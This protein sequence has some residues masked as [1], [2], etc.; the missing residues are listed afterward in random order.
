MITWTIKGGTVLGPA[1][2]IICGIV[3]VTPD[4][5]YDG[6]RH[7]SAEAAAA[8]GRRLAAEG[9]AVL[10]VGGESTRPGSEAVDEETE[11]SRV[12]PVVRALAPLSPDAA[13]SVD[14]TKAAVAVACLAAGAA[15]INDVSACRFDPA[16]T[17]VLAQHKPGY[18]LMHA[19]G[20]PRTMQDDPRYGDVVADLKAFFAGHLGRLV[21]AGLPED[22]IVLDPGIGFGKTLE[23][24]LE[25]L[26]RIEEFMEFGRPVYMALSN[27]SLFGRL[28]GFGPDE[29]QEATRIAS[30]LLQARGV[31]IHRLHE[32][33]PAVAALRL[34]EAMRPGGE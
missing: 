3:N 33:A 22:R 19:Q 21:R 9:A 8:Q 13:V 5:F 12:L 31:R 27:K 1:P 20:E 10:D 32:V 30:A 17:D 6:G 16:L 2:H 14:T 7:A 18:V 28:L 11:I 23:H 25:I 15:I 4:S 26:R 29:R 34:A 24:N